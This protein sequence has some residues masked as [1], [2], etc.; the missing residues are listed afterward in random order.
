VP[1]IERA[2]S[3][4]KR[5]RLLEA[6]RGAVAEHG[7]AVPAAEI[8][9]RAE[10]GVGTLYR[11]FGSKEA[12]I[13]SVLIE[14]LEGVT[15]STRTALE[16]P[17]PGDGLEMLLVSLAEARMASKGLFEALTSSPAFD[18]SSLNEHSKIVRSAF[19][20][21]TERA[22]RAGLVREDVTWRDVVVMGYAA[23]SAVGVLG[24]T[25]GNQQWRRNYAVLLDGLRPPGHR[26]PPGEPP[27]DGLQAL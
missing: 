26:P 6:A 3:R 10:V 23:A 9:A 24:I 17:D 22:Q 20:T 11:R 4:R 16:A 27:E 21:L 1:G 25:V 15:A 8:A 13:E 12:L 18:R 14:T 19:E 5:L 2:D 7:L